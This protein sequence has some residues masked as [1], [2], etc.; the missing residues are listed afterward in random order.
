MVTYW[1]HTDSIIDISRSSIKCIW[2]IY[3]RYDHNKFGML[4]SYIVNNIV[5]WSHI[6]YIRSVLK[7]NNSNQLSVYGPYTV[8]MV[9][10]NLKWYRIILLTIETYCH[11]LDTHGQYYRCITV[12]I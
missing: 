2:A 4:S 7:M 5:I 9:I 6:G 11:I 10:I 12:V 8:N 1:I 3:K